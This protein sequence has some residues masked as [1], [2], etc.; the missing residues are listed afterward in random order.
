[1]AAKG[2]QGDAADGYNFRLILRWLRHR[3]R[4]I[5]DARIP[6]SALIPAF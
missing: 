4:Q 1:M 3:L 2:R 5:P 6:G